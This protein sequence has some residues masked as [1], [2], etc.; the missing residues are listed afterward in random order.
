MERENTFFWVTNYFS[1]WQCLTSSYKWFN[2]ANGHG[3]RIA[4]PILTGNLTTWQYLSFYCRFNT[5]N[6]HRAGISSI[7]TISRPITFRLV[8]LLY[9]T[10]CL[11]NGVN[12]LNLSKKSLKETRKSKSELLFSD[13]IHNSGKRWHKLIEDKGKYFDAINPYSYTFISL[14]RYYEFLSKNSLSRNMLETFVSL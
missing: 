14:F 2:A 7:F 9:N 6:V 3:D 8:L 12:M 10:S 5:I 4:N 13:G 11:A 1:L